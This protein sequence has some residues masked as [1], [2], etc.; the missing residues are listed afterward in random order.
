MVIFT[1]RSD[2]VPDAQFSTPPDSTD[3]TRRKRGIIIALLVLFAVFLLT[4][5][6]SM[7]GG[8][9]GMAPSRIFQISVDAPEAGARVAFPIV[10]TGSARED[11]YDNGT[12]PIQIWDGRNNLLVTAVG[13]AET[14]PEQ[15]RHAP[16]KA[17]IESF[18][19]KPETRIG[20][21]VIHRKTVRDNPSNDQFF[22]MSIEFANG[23]GVGAKSGTVS[24]NK[25][26]ST[27]SATVTGSG[28]TSL[29]SASG[30]STCAD[31][32]DNDRDGRRDAADPDCHTDKNPNNYQ[33]FSGSR[34]E[35]PETTKNGGVKIIQKTDSSS[36][37]TT[38]S[39]GSIN[40]TGGTAG[41][42][43]FSG[44]GG[45][46]SSCGPNGTNCWGLPQ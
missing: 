10:I 36:A 45:S 34:D 29:F 39:A 37:T 16:F 26:T 30:P 40:N 12:I 7:G 17:V 8:S 33:T 27:S 20:R 15:G 18:D 43:G 42:G 31:G 14:S 28:V 24:V 3:Y 9:G 25:T 4:V 1:P 13:I 38:S 44:S 32:Y 35:D 22:S 41:A 23:Y 5:G 6:G 21:I 11:W 46:P 2:S 19:T